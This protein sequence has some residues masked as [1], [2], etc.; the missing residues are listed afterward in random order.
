MKKKGVQVVLAI[1]VIGG[2]LVAWWATR[3]PEVQ[4]ADIETGVTV[5]QELE[6]E[7]EDMDFEI[8]DFDEDVIFD[9]P[10]DTTE[11]ETPVNAELPV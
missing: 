1:L 11:G 5:D 4:E 2:A 9:M 8:P 6:D 3:P 7:M 10:L